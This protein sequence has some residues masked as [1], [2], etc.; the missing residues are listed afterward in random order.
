MAKQQSNA[1][2]NLQP[3]IED[4]QIDIEAEESA[5]SSAPQL[6]VVEGDATVT[7]EEIQAL[8]ETMAEQNAVEDVSAI[9]ESEP[10]ISVDESGSNLD[11]TGEFD[12][13][14]PTNVQVNPEPEAEAEPELVTK[15][16]TMDDV[17][18]AAS[19][20][21]S[22]SI[23]EIKNLEAPVMEASSESLD[24][25]VASLDDVP[26]DAPILESI[27]QVSPE[28]AGTVASTPNHAEVAAEPTSNGSEKKPKSIG[29]P[30][31]GVSNL[32]QALPKAFP[33]I[34][35]LAA[36]GLVYG[37]TMS[38]ITRVSAAATSRDK[39]IT[40]TL[41]GVETL[42]VGQGERLAKIDKYLV[43]G[44][45]AG[46]IAKTD[47]HSENSSHTAGHPQS[48]TDSHAKSDSHGKDG[49]GG[50]GDGS[51]GHSGDTHASA[52]T[53][54]AGHDD[55]HGKVAESH[56]KDEHAKAS[57]AHDS[58]GDQGGDHSAT[59]STHSETSYGTPKKD[60]H[61]SPNS[62]GTDSGAKHPVASKHTDSH[63][64]AGDHGKVPQKHETQAQK[65]AHLHASGSE[66]FKV[67]KAPAPKAWHKEPHTIV[68]TDNHK[69]A[70]SHKRSSHKSSGHTVV[71]RHGTKAHGSGAKK[72]THGTVA[73]NKPQPKS[74]TIK[75]YLD[76]VHVSSSH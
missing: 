18:K 16:V 40:E 31:I 75:V 70:S 74:G 6:E 66:G 48:P 58:H 76:D 43:S 36:A 23:D 19:A 63:G 61:T 17:L 65:D 35:S 71:K 37:L 60:A 42:V 47:S 39:K 10:T 20:A 26:F 72:S 50:G 22:L 34:A 11:A 55:Q 4:I 46:L 15:K 52:K 57:T 28:T 68:T 33:Y 30:K 13:V 27:P 56:G 9:N 64:S 24:A 69:V 8:L 21:T 73:Q 44:S 3:E 45:G 62:H 32:K 7:N 51:D 59:K 12:Q 67:A 2:E 53:G 41:E 38:A 5:E 25:E 14:E 1:A 29:K 49:H 54:S